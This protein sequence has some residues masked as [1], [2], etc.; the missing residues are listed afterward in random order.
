MLC[1]VIITEINK[2]L[3]LI[4]DGEKRGKMNT[5]RAYFLIS[6]LGSASFLEA[7][8]QSDTLSLAITGA[9]LGNTELQNK[10]EERIQADIAKS[11]AKFIALSRKKF[12][13]W[14]SGGKSVPRSDQPTET[15]ELIA[16]VA[17]QKGR[18]YELE[19]KLE[20]LD[21]STSPEGNQAILVHPKEENNESIKQLVSQ[22]P[23]KSEYTEVDPR[24]IVRIGGDFYMQKKDFPAFKAPMDFSGFKKGSYYIK[25]SPEATSALLMLKTQESQ[26]QNRALFSMDEEYVEIPESAIIVIQGEY[27]TKKGSIPVTVF[28]ENNKGKEQSYFYVRKSD[29]AKEH[30][31]KLMLEK[32]KV[33]QKPRVVYQ[34]VPKKTRGSFYAKAS[35]ASLGLK[36]GKHYI[37]REGASYDD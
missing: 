21:K 5:L 4:V 32:R 16:K 18:T 10:A 8:S 1:L 13:T 6:V 26:V 29:I 22:D 15:D 27:Y 3:A 28:R 17:V 37:V 12:M 25:T 24:F 11:L 23:N 7:A 14:I 2:V 36:K 30:P 19:K 31:K 34:E 9:A 35:V 33:E 20:N